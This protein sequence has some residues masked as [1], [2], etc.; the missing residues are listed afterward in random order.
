[1]KHVL[2]ATL[3]LPLMAC[4]GGQT[5]ATAEVTQDSVKNPRQCKESSSGNHHDTPQHPP[6]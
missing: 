1:M 4:G 3:L 5:Q 2:I 6:V